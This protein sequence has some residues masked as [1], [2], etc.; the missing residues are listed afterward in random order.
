VSTCQVETKGISIKVRWSQATSD[1]KKMSRQADSISQDLKGSITQNNIK[2]ESDWDI[3]TKYIH[4]HCTQ[5]QGL[6]RE[7]LRGRQVL[8]D[9]AH[10]DADK[11]KQDSNHPASL[12][13]RSADQYCLG[14]HGVQPISQSTSP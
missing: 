12:V 6:P 5:M 11:V 7:Q 10:T 1:R 3:L 2:A 14:I 4:T 13:D 8:A 9:S